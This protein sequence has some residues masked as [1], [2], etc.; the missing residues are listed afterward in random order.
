MNK[1]INTFNSMIEEFNKDIKTVYGYS[2]IG[3]T[4]QVND[5]Q[6]KDYIKTRT[7]NIMVLELAK[8]GIVS[9]TGMSDIITD[10][11]GKI[12]AQEDILEEEQ[13]NKTTKRFIEG[14]IRRFE[15]YMSILKVYL[16]KR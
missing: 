4:E 8:I 6:L 5:E 3:D 15:G 2:D 11:E 1:E 12:A 7:D 10:L 9:F 14:N 16:I 13:D